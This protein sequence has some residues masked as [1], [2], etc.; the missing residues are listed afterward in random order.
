MKNAMLMDYWLKEI[1]GDDD[2]NEREMN[3]R[4]IRLINVRKEIRF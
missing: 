3:N 4:K 1:L 2:E